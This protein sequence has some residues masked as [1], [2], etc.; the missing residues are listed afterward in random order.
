M[1]HPS[2]LR[3]RVQPVRLDDEEESVRIPRH[4]ILL[5][6]VSQCKM[7]FSINVTL[8]ASVAKAHCSSFSDAMLQSRIG[9]CRRVLSALLFAILAQL[10][11]LHGAETDSS[12]CSLGQATRLSLSRRIAQVPVTHAKLQVDGRLYLFLTMLACVW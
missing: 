4:A 12:T 11:K 7:T 10:K 1:A 5:S 9:C 6:A 8:N 3:D 2:A